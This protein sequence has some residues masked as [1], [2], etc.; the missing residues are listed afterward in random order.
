MVMGGFHPTLVPEETGEFAEAVV[1]G[2]AEKVW[3]E[4]LEDFE[5]GRLQKFYRSALGRNRTELQ[6]VKPDR[7]LFKG[8]GICRF[9][10]WSRAEDVI[11]LAVFVLS[12]VFLRALN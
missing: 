8:K 3:P 7:S 5:N 2:E 10:W 9:A 1:V 12:Q 4:L 6:A 11:S